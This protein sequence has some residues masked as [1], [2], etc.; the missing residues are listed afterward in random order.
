MTKFIVLKSGNIGNRIKSYISHMAK[1]DEV[2]S[3]NYFDTCL[4]DNIKYA[5]DKDLETYPSTGSVWRLL[6]DPNEEKYIKTY[7]SIDFLYN[8][9]PEYFKNKY[10][11]FFKKLQININVQNKINEFIKNWDKEN[12]IGIS[13]RSGL[14][15]MEDGH[16]SKWVDYST[17]EKEIESLST[18]QKCFLTTDNLNILN[19]FK[20]KYKDK[21]LIREIRDPLGYQIGDV[22]ASS[23]NIVEDAFIDMYLLSQCYNKLIVTFGSTYP[24]CAWWFGE[25]RAKVI[26][27]TIWEHVPEEFINNHFIKK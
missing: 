4:F 27:P 25:C 7:N 11:P 3:T 17:Y 23:F 5:S 21:I 24:E 14:P 13:I 10:I 6:V 1:Y 18:S 9:T 22:R 16:R 26:T 15:P 19:Y 12:M 2:L 20:N 8:E